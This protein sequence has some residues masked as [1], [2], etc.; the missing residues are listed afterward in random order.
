MTQPIQR[1]KAEFFKTLANPARIRILEVLHDGERSVGELIPE[2]GIESSHLSQQLGIL[3]R[4]NILQ[5][6]KEGSAVFY[7]VTDPR[8]FDLLEVARA[9]LTSSL[10]ET[11]QLLAELQ[12]GRPLARSG[13]VPDQ[14]GPAGSE[15]GRKRSSS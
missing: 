2:V 9:I 15:G 12:A 6:R 11:S 1:M 3:R 14:H 10:A 8:M 7:S 13:S 5:M 4:A